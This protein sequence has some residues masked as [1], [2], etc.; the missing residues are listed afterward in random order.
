MYL[1]I[2]KPLLQHLDCPGMEETATIQSKQ[3]FQ[4]RSDQSL[5]VFDSLRPHESQFF[6]WGQ[7]VFL[8][9]E[10]HL[11]SQREYFCSVCALNSCV[12]SR[13]PEKEVNSILR[14]STVVSRGLGC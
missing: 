5:G 14:T 11:N 4:I 10:L 8:S 12:S 2:L 3:F 9:L 7:N 1:Q 6:K 13:T